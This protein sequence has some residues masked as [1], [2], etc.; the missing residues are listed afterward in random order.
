METG[1]RQQ[2]PR[3]TWD[4]I[5]SPAATPDKK[6]AMSEREFPLTHGPIKPSAQYYSVAWSSG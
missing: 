1:Q 2:Q 4:Q 5:R 6:K 3:K